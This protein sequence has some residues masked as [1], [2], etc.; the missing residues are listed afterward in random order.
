MTI[1]DHCFKFGIM[2]VFTPQGKESKD[3]GNKNDPL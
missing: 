3:W 1:K 2:E